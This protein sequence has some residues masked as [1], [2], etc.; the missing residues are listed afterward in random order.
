MVAV[1]ARRVAA[2]ET[3]SEIARPPDIAAGDQ[4]I[5]GL[6]RALVVGQVGRHVQD[7]RNASYE[8]GKQS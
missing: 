4:R 2:Q 1:V 7:A 6:G 3:F 8:P 5:E